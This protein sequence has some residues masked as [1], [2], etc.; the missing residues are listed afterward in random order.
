MR[1]ARLIANQ[2]HV[3]FM[4]LLQYRVD[5]ALSLLLACFWTLSAIVPLLVLYSDRSSVAGWSWGE[6]L[7]VVGW[8]NVLKGVQSIVI[9]PSMNQAVEQI[10]KGTLDFVLMKPAD[11]QILVSSQRFDFRQLSDVIVGLV[12]LVYALVTLRVVPTP[13][14]ILETLVSLLCATVILYAIWVM[15]MS[16]AFVFV[17]VDNLTFLF[18]SI[19]DA[20]R[21]P[22]S[23]FRGAF[24][25]VFTFV[26]PLTLMT[27]TPA[28]AIL[29]RLNAK[30]LL[31]ALGGAALFTLL[32]RWVWKACIARYTSAGG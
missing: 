12:I 5:F 8:F 32:S 29:G 24:A 11:A 19:Y 7:V 10:R 14:A 30:E 27:T 22:G 13:L 2:A 15:V 26:L 6:A 4:L 16:L 23:I 20:A 9:Q 1:Y 28:L 21:W 18:Q 3:S 17:K 25:I 31:L